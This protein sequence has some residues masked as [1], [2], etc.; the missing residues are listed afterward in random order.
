MI[1]ATGRSPHAAAPTASPRKPISEIGV[2]R[3]RSGPKR[4]EQPFRRLERALGD[5]HVLTEDDDARVLIHLV[6][7]R[8]G[9]RLAHPHLHRTL[10]SVAD[11]TFPVTFLE[12]YS[13]A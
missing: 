2:S 9:D 8:L 10:R 5:R 11:Q 13:G 6:G 12:H 3:T 7:E 4:V 1:S